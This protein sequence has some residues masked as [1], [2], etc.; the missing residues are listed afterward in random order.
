MTKVN[1]ALFNPIIRRFAGYI[2]P[3]AIIN[4]RGRS[5]DKAYSTPILAFP[6]DDGFIVALVYGRNT[7]WERNVVS[8]GGCD[9]FYRTTHHALT[10]PR[11]MG[12]DEAR[13]FLPS[14]MHTGFRLIRV[15]SFLRLDR[16]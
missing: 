16:P 9:L 1:R 7:D 11:I 8:A 3:L 13:A 10:A 5:S 4:H 2:P 6:A 12:P 15:D 14:V